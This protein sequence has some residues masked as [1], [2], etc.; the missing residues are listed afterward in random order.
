[1]KRRS[2]RKQ[3]TAKTA[4]TRKQKKELRRQEALKQQ[5]L[6]NNPSPN[7]LSIIGSKNPSPGVTPERLNAPGEPQTP[8]SDLS[9]LKDRNATQNS[10][11]LE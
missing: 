9:L 11:I 8:L 10:N 1:M 6:A 7:S 4:E 2:L 3:I 5:G